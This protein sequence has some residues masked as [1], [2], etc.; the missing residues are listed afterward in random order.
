MADEEASAAV[1]SSSKKLE[2]VSPR[3]FLETVEVGYAIIK[4][5]KVLD[6]VSTAFAP[7]EACAVMGPSGAGKTTLLNALACRVKGIEGRVLANGVAISTPMEF[8]AWGTVAPQD[9]V[10]LPNLTVGELLFYARKLRGGKQS[11]EAL[12]STFELAE[13][14]DVKS[15]FL[16]GGQKKRLSICLEL[17]HRPSVLFCDEPTSGLDSRVALSVVSTLSTLAHQTKTNVVATVH[18]PSLECFLLFDRV[19]ILAAGKVAYS[20]TVERAVD[21]FSD[22][23]EGQKFGCKNP[24]DLAID[25][26]S[27]GQGLIPGILTALFV[28]LERST[29]VR[30]CFNGVWRL[31]EYLLARTVVSAVVHVAGCTV[32]SLFFYYMIDLKGEFWKFVSPLYFLGIITQQLGLILGSVFGTATTSVP[33]FLPLNISAVM[34][35]GFFFTIHDLTKSI[36]KVLYPFWYLSWYRYVYAILL[37]NEFQFGTFDACDSVCPYDSYA[38]NQVPNVNRDVIIRDYLDIDVYQAKHYYVFYLLLFILSFYTIMF[39]LVKHKA[40]KP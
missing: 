15:K 12:L 25:A 34:C 5:A 7:G 37:T 13:R 18:Q 11:V 1:F 36:Q 10:V 35:A 39:L 20:G 16:S 4:G 27:K 32:F 23:D 31:K 29:L 33:A 21:E 6:H 38:P 26:V 8:A 9:D 40:L 14:K 17:A 3:V 19:L 2:D 22:D 30:E 28:P 24:A